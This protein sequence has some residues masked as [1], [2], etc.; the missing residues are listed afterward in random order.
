MQHVFAKNY[1]FEARYVGTR[2]VH[3]WNQTQLNFYPQVSA[4]NYI[5]TFLTMPSPGTLAGLTQTLGNVENYITPGGTPDDGLQLLRAAIGSKAKMTA[6]APQANSLYNGLALVT[7]HQVTLSERFV[8]YRTAYTWSHLEDDATATNFST[9]LTPR[10]AQDAGTSRRI[11]PTE[12]KILPS[13]LHLHAR[14]TTSCSSKTRI[15][16]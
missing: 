2:G 15:G 6:Y 11:G 10:R 5:P 13:T 1:T 3:L 4:N 9:Y 14:H 16:F 8:V 7:I 12:L